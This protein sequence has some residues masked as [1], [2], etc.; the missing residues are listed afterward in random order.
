M[1]SMVR[2]HDSVRS[3]RSDEAPQD[4]QGE[5]GTEDDGRPFRCVRFPSFITQT[6]VGDR[7]KLTPNRYGNCCCI[8]RSRS[9][10]STLRHRS[11]F[12]ALLL[13]HG[14][15]TTLG[16]N[17]VSM[18]IIGPLCGLNIVIKDDSSGEI[19]ISEDIKQAK[20]LDLNI[21]YIN[22]DSKQYSD[23]SVTAQNS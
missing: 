8:V 7:I 22:I 17:C 16:A 6:A 14:G 23:R 3:G 9:M 10:F 5:S 1:C 19:D 2:C 11:G 21:Y 20:S 13:A 4:S 15:F 18:G 12:Q